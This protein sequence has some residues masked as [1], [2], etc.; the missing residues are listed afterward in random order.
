MHALKIR[1]QSFAVKNI[2]LIIGLAVCAPLYFANALKYS[3]PMGYAGLFAQMAKQI[4]EENF[5]LP[6]ES[7]FYG[8]GG[9]PFAYPPAGL[10]MLAIFI[11]LTG[12]YFV[13]LR[14]LPPFLGL[15]SF[16]PLYY[17]ALELTKSK[18]AAVAAIVIAATSPDLYVAHAW[19]AGIVRAPAFIFALTSIYFHLR[20]INNPSGPGLVLA[21]VFFGLTCMSHLMYAL[22]CFLWI[23]WWSIFGQNIYQKIRGALT[24]SAIGA[25]IASIWLVPV[26][27]RYGADV[28]FRAFDSHGGDALFSFWSDPSVLLRLFL[29]NFT[30]ISS[31]PIL[32]ILVLI[33]TTSMLARKNFAFLLLYLAVVLAFP[34]SSRFVFLMGSIAAGLG[35]SALAHGVTGILPVLLRPVLAVGLLIPIFGAIWWEGYAALSKQTPR[36]YTTTLDLA[37]RIQAMMPADQT[38]LALVKQDEAEWMPFLF[39]R[40][41]AV[42]QWGSEWL[43][44]YNEQVHFMALFHECEK[45]QDW[46]CVQDALTISSIQPDYLVSYVTD[47]ELND[48]IML[49]G[50]WGQIY[51][52]DRYLFWK[53]AD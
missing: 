32:L 35:I 31:Y 16:I 43:G 49:D 14:L 8:P 50:R 17:L 28:F 39:Q 53:I 47:M 34:E 36:L 19:A 1:F 22:F 40:E 20:Q 15:V 9:I 27:I 21:G 29:G 45:D 33:G 26:L 18:V 12:K 24:V 38:Y 7:P 51:E 4:A 41:P 13:F 46:A 42:A 3:V 25:L 30:P 52:N 23:W 10:Y 37:E 5:H 44:N 2:H 6:M 48:N 11:K